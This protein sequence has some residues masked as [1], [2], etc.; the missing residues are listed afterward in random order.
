MPDVNG[1]SAIGC[2]RSETTAMFDP[3]PTD[4]PPP[5]KTY[6]SKPK[7]DYDGSAK[8]CPEKKNTPNGPPKTHAQTETHTPAGNG[9]KD[10]TTATQS[11]Q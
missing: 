6:R 5:A 2:H 3:N 8:G 11:I 1:D 7:K 9:E 10:V 4:P